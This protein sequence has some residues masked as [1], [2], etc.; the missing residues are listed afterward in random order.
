[1]SKG[2]KQDCLWKQEIKPMCALLQQQHSPGKIGL[3]TLSPSL[4]GPNR[5]RLRQMKIG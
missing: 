1:M 3:A 2:L 5:K 4:A